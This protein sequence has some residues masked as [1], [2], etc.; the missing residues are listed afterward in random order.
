MCCFSFAR[1]LVSACVHSL[2][3]RNRA[4][5]VWAVILAVFTLAGPALGAGGTI[6]LISVKDPAGAPPV[7]GHDCSLAD[8]A[9]D[10]RFVV[11]VASGNDFTTNDT[12][13][14]MLGGFLDVFVRDRAS[15]QTV[16][17]SAT[18]NGLASG[19]GDSFG[20]SI[21]HDG[22]FVAFQSK[23]DDLTAGDTNQCM[24]V[25]VRDLLLGITTPVS[26]R[27]DG[28]A[29]GDA[30]S[31][32]PS[33]TPDGRFVV[34]DSAASDLVPGDT[35]GIV[36]VFLRDLRTGTTLLISTN[37]QA[38]GNPFVRSEWASLST[39]GQRVAF[40]SAATNLVAEAV[41]GLPQVYVRDWVLGTTT[42]ASGGAAKVTGQTN[43]LSFDEAAMSADG[44]YIVFS[45]PAVASSGASL[46]RYEVD[47]GTTE[48][49]ATN[50]VSGW[51]KPSV[52]ADGRFVA[53]EG[54][55]DK[56]FR[57][58]A[59]YRWDALPRILEL[60]SFNPGGADAPG[61]M[62]YQPL[63]SS[64]GRFVGYLWAVTNLTGQPEQVSLCVRDMDL[65]TTLQAS[66][67][68]NGE[69]LP[70][71][72]DWALTAEDWRW[73]AF[74]TVEPGTEEDQNGMYDVYLLNLESETIEWIS[75]WNPPRTG[76]TGNGWSL[77]NRLSADGRFL[78]FKSS[79]DNLVPGDTNGLQDIF[80][81]DLE[82]D[83]T[84]LVSVNTNGAA[85]NGVSTDPLLS[86]DGR[87]VAFVSLA[88]DL[89]SGDTNRLH[90]LY[91]RD[92]AAGTNRLV[93][94]DLN[95]NAASID[96]AASI[97]LSADGRIA[98]F[99]STGSNLVPPEPGESSRQR[100][101]FWHDLQARTTV[102][103]TPPGVPLSRWFACSADGRTVAYDPAAALGDLAVWDATTRSQRVFVFSEL[104]GDCQPAPSSDLRGGQLSADGNVL[105]YFIGVETG[106]EL[107]AL[108]FRAERVEV[109]G[110]ATYSSA[111]PPSISPDGRWVAYV[112][113]ALPSSDGDHNNAS[114]IALFD[115][116]TP[117]S[118]LLIQN[119]AGTG[120]PNG[121]SSMPRMSDDG[122]WI[123]FRSTA[124]DLVADEASG[125]PGVFL[126]D[127]E[128]GT[129]ELL[130]QTAGGGPVLGMSSVPLI[131]P[132]GKTV[133]F[134]SLADG[135]AAGDC[136]EAMDIFALARDVALPLRVSRISLTGGGAIVIE[137]RALPGMTYQVEYKDDLTAEPWFLSPGVPVTE[138]GACRF[139][140]P[141]APANHARFYRLRAAAP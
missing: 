101:L 136:N 78:V 95:G 33:M 49:V 125:Q 14:G 133:A 92:L 16:L 103:V 80:L 72:F 109:I 36:D 17:V 123:V 91:V 42:W 25:F 65:G 71:V 108:D 60:A 39:N 7:R 56:S 47:T 52:S 113:S 122:R 97:A 93:S 62:A 76:I 63:I 2:L 57:S 134:Q 6:E 10:G 126:F 23:A 34:F 43:R 55:R 77:L 132:D 135:L 21:S 124:S 27:H 46:L 67:S 96:P 110:L 12:A 74:S 129:V 138:D 114:D 105:F 30:D 90:D 75:C 86:A 61:G 84:V 8:L 68:S 48:L 139:T 70:G 18:A 44:R 94:R 141:S 128:N 140:D 54:S 1:N 28:L 37:A 79:A 19:N 115:R 9:P 29:T 98:V 111:A 83:R 118:T 64:D 53:F 89:A 117:G 87:S 106:Y 130:S 112:T 24:D 50:L 88:S 116:R 45:V 99:A 4:A 3:L 38:A 73:A 119:A 59:V 121:A 13:A 69:V 85:A 104:P 131:S 22:R 51:G 120:T 32:T 5:G 107:R 100:H 58:T 20:A 40:L 82:T 41:N 11:F 31:A 81:R 26:V 127:R 15:N 102:R 137:W 66:A 35:N